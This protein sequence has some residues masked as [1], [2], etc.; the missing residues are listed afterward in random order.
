MVLR[1]TM[2]GQKVGNG[3]I[4]GNPFPFPPNNQGI[5][6]IIGE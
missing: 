3:P 6:E 1:L 4:P 5:T 2:K